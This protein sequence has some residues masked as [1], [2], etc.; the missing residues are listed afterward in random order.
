MEELSAMQYEEG[1]KWPRFQDPSF[2][3]RLE[4]RVERNALALSTSSA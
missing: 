4:D 2:E 1:L 3:A